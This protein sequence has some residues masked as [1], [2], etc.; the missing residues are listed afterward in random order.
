[1][2]VTLRRSKHTLIKLA[3]NTVLQRDILITAMKL[4]VHEEEFVKKLLNSPPILKPEDHYSVLKS[5]PLVP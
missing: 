4:L 1:M 3:L 2:A 5:P